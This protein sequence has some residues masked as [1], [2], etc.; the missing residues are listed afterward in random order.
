[1]RHMEVH[2][3]VDIGLVDL[4]RLE[5]IGCWTLHIGEVID[6]GIILVLDLTG[7][8]IV[9]VIILTR[10]VIGDTFKMSL[11]KKKHLLD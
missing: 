1:M 2:L 3:L 11:R 7:I 4:T 6:I 10:G 8:M 9:I 5:M